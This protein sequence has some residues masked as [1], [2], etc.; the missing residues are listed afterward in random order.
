MFELELIA[1]ADGALAAI[2]FNPRAYGSMALAIAAGRAAARDLV[3]LAA[4]RVGPD[5][6]GDRARRRPDTDGRTP[7]PATSCG[8]RGTAVAEALRAL[9]PGPGVT[10]AYFQLRDPLPG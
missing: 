6:A 5:L 9:W 10:H 1:P 7:T 8:G 4:V 3:R 2:D